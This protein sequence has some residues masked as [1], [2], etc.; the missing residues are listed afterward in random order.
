MGC[1][2]PRSVAF[3]ILKQAVL[4]DKAACGVMAG[5]FCREKLPPMLFCRLARQ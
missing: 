4:R 2:V 1:F 5:G 3:G